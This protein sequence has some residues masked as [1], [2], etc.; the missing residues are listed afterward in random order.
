LETNRIE[1]LEANLE[2]FRSVNQQQTK[3]NVKFL[4]EIEE[5][6]IELNLLKAKND[7]SQSNR[8]RDE[9]DI[10]RLKVHAADVHTKLEQ[11]GPTS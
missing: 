9:Q 1:D 10:S 7:Q 5:L 11:V 6:S 2:E 4:K 3:E 8:Q